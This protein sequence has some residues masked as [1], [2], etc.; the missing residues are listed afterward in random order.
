MLYIFIWKPVF[1]LKISLMQHDIIG[2]Q[3]LN[4]GNILEGIVA[5]TRKG[6]SK[7]SSLNIELEIEVK[8]IINYWISCSS[9]YDDDFG[10]I[11]KKLSIG[12]KLMKK[13]GYEGKCVGVNGHVIVD[14]IHVVDLICRTRIWKRGRWIILQGYRWKKPQC[15]RSNRI[16]K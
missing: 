12:L 16:F 10:A 6:L 1:Y 7:P 13:M 2:L 14:L 5:T 15:H 9:H 3:N 4:E 8:N 11:E